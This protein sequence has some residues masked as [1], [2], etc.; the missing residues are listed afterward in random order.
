M[1]NI[2][3]T[4]Q[5]LTPFMLGCL[6]FIHDW[7]DLKLKVDSERQV[8]DKLIRAILF[9]LSFCQKSAERKSPKKYFFIFRFVGDVKRGVLTVASY[10]K[11]QH[12]TYQTTSNTKKSIRNYI[13]V[14][15]SVTAVGNCFP[16]KICVL[17]ITVD[18]W[19]EEQII[20]GI[21]ITGRLSRL[22]V[23]YFSDLISFS[24]IEFYRN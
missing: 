4:T 19:I 5:F 8:F 23:L 6:N 15:C 1:N 18:G 3:L 20:R 11:N 21:S 2:K 7:P 13:S 12:T 9:T 17:H 22:V 10:L 16:S 14:A 24:G